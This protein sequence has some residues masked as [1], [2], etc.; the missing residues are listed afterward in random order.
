MRKGAIQSN[1]VASI[2]YA[3]TLVIIGLSARHCMKKYGGRKKRF[4]R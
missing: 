1:P 4:F 3:V 2:G